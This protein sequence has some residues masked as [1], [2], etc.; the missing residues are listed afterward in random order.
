M[1][2]IYLYSTIFVHRVLNNLFLIEL[3]P[4]KLIATDSAS[5]QIVGEGDFM[6]LP[7]FFSDT[8]YETFLQSQ[9]FLLGA[10]S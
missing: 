5:L 1:Y 9:N 7:S 2:S 8:A 3:S 10:V 6:F 4:S